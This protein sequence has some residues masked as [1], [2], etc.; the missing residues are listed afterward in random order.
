[1]A[2]NHT[3]S[4]LESLRRQLRR[5]A[6]LLQGTTVPGGAYRPSDHSPIVGDHDVDGRVVDQYWLNA[7]FSYAVISYDETESQHRYHAIEPDLDRFESDLLETLYDD[8][9]APLLYEKR[10]E[11]PEEALRQELRRRL[12][13]YGTNIDTATVYRLFYYLYRRFQGF[14]RLDPL[15]YDPH[16]EDISCDGYELPLYIYHDDY[17]DIES[18]ITFDRDELD[19]YII[20]MAQQSGRH[21]SVGNP[22]VETTLQDG[23]RAELALGEEVTPRGSAF[24]VRKYSDEPF[25]PID[26]LEYGTYSLEQMAYLWMAIEHNK[27]IVFAGGT[28]SGK[29]T[30]MNAI[31]MFIPPRSKLITIEDTR[32]LSL[33]HDNWLSCVT[34]ERLDEGADVTMYDLLRSSLRHR[35]EYIIVGE[36]RGEEAIT[37]FQAMNTGHTTLS[38]MHAD[39][40]QTVINRLENE[41]INVPRPMVQSLDVL[42]VQ[43][44]ARFGGERVRRASTIAEI[45]GIDQRTGELDYTNA[46]RWESGSDEF[47]EGTRSLM[48][49]IR[50]ERGWSQSELLRELQR[51]R[52]VL[53]FLQERGV[54]EY[55]RFT[56][57]VNRYYASPDTVMQRI[58]EAETDLDTDLDDKSDQQQA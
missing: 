34:R 29:T 26:L 40:V 38:T 16:I 58:E 53:Q 30:S 1:M 10:D 14:G 25:T 9:R 12:Q 57:M 2:S 49:E 42:C 27:N 23:S 32:E 21:I 13:Q 20:R 47:R 6:E 17:Q 50:E 48:D 46:Y 28:A 36:V 54:N 18:N 39:S 33:Y 52:L 5:T 7:P 4:R 56:A 41:P 8:V 43:T 37:L 35:P 44:L 22:I 15:M 31:S 24:T 55:Q 51:R 11:P 45:E 3:D 19:N